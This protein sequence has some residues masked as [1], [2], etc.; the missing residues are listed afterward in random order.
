MT[1]ISDA[2]KNGSRFKKST[3]IWLVVSALL[4][5]I[6]VVIYVVGTIKISNRNDKINELNA[7]LEAYNELSK[8]IGVG[9][10]LTRDEIG[11]IFSTYEIESEKRGSGIY[12]KLNPNRN[13]ANFDGFYVMT[14]SVMTVE[15]FGFIQY[16]D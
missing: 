8:K 16:N 5:A 13:I 3:R 4:L 10:K 14:D 1:Q 12:Y 6:L 9:K 11:A 2:R 7:K 15:D